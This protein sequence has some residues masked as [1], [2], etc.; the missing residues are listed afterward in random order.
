MEEGYRALIENI[1]LQAVGDYRKALRIL[2]RYPLCKM[3]LGM[4][5]NTEEFFSSDWFN[6]LTN[7]D[8]KTL[9]ERLQEEA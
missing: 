4:K 2:R 8:G 3:A 1:V 5:R 7:L 6:T 9:M